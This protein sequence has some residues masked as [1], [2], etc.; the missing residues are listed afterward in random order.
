MQ[1]NESLGIREFVCIC[2]ADRMSPLVLVWRVASEEASVYSAH[3]HHNCA[4][5]MMTHRHL[6]TAALCSRLTTKSPHTCPLTLQLH[7]IWHFV[8]SVSKLLKW[9]T[10]FQHRNCTL[11]PIFRRR[12]HRRFFKLF[13]WRTLEIQMLLCIDMTTLW[14]SRRVLLN[15]C[16]T[17]FGFSRVLVGSR[18]S[19]GVLCCAVVCCCFRRLSLLVAVRLVLFFLFGCES[20]GVVG[21][22]VFDCNK[23]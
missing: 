16:V 19:R 6:L 9:A 22:V 11:I 21:V 3:F 14:F 13:S 18:A 10:F 17:R 2:D 12:F 1:S 20:S 23:R 4:H 7:I 8:E 15:W 5:I